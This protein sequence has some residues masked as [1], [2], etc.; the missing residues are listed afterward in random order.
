[1]GDVQRDVD[2]LAQRG[3]GAGAGA[4]GAVLDQAVGIVGLADVIRIGVVELA[5]AIDQ[6]EGAVHPQRAVRPF[7]PRLPAGAR[8]AVFFMSVGPA[9]GAGVGLA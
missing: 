2:R 1:M 9:I 6:I 7:H 4:P 5:L 8:I 3:F